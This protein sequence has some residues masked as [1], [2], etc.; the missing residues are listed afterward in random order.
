VMFG[1]LSSHSV[2]YESFS[3]YSLPLGIVEVL[4]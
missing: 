2:N 1:M 4:L 3:K